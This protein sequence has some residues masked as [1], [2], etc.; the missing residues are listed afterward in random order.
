MYIYELLDEGLR[1]VKDI[2]RPN[3]QYYDDYVRKHGGGG[4]D[5][6]RDGGSDGNENDGGS[7]CNEDRRW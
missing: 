1:Y 3:V 6:N 7:G 4:G 2:D 5:K